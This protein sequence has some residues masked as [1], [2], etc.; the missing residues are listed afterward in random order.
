MKI[1]AIETSTKYLGLSVVSEEGLIAEHSAL[2]ER[3]TSR[4]LVSGIRD[5]LKYNNMTLDDISAIAVS[6]G[7]GSFTGLRIGVTTA[8]GMGI[9]SGKLVV[10]VPTLDVLVRNAVYFFGNICAVVDAKKNMVYS[11]LYQAKNAKI[12][13]KSKYVVEP[14]KDT[15]KKTTG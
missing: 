9:S 13:R 15:L 10:G 6:I 12:S 3:E 14:I 5:M 4:F 1:L 2:L 11:A 7:P 8:K